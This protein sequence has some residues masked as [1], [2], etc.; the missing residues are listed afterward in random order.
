MGTMV[1]TAARREVV[2]NLD[3]AL[4]LKVGLAY[5]TVQNRT[6]QSYDGTSLSV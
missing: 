1:L 6:R 5:L 4:S 3:P 2:E